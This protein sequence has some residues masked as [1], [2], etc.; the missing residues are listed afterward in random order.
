[1]DAILSNVFVDYLLT[2]IPFGM[3]FLFGCTG[4]IITEKVGHLNLGIPGIMCMG[5]AFGCFALKFLGKTG[6]SPV[7]IVILAIIAAFIGGILMGLIFSFLTVTLKSNQNVTGLAMTTFG[8]GTTKYIMSSMATNA[9]ESYLYALKYFRYPFANETTSLKYCGVMV[10]LAIIIALVTSYVLTRTKVGLHLRAVGENPATA[11]AVGINV[12][13]YKYYATCIGSGIAA[14]GGLFYIMDFSG[15]LESYKNI[16]ALGWLAIALVIFTLWRPH[17]S[18]IGSILFGMLYLAGSYIPTMLGIELDLS[19][20]PFLKMLP[21]VVTILV[22][23]IT[24]VSK[25]REN[26]PPQGLGIPYFREDR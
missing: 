8:V 19:A 15:S 11:D 17:I 7:L 13:K 3:T 23:I 4:E 12:T 16:E 1:M 24:S 20:T 26:Q 21:Y 14:L 18:I 9:T 5:G 25:K 22:L 2:A 10:F 6:M